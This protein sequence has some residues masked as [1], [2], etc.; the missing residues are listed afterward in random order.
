MGIKERINKLDKTLLLLG[1]IVLIAVVL[2][3][4]T[5]GWQQAF[6]GFKQAGQLI[7]TVWLRLLLGF[8]LG[9]LVQVLI[10]R[11][12]IAKWLG[13]ASGLKGILIGSYMSII[14]PGSPYVALPI[15]ASIYRAGAGVGPVIAL[16]T[17][18]GILEIQMLVVWEIPFLGVEIP[19]ARYVACLL[20]PPIV[21][22]MGATVFRMITK[23]SHTADIDNI[24]IGAIEQQN[25]SGKNYKTSEEEEKTE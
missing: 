1:A 6:K 25:K 12:L 23:L 20:I 3:L 19:L 15:I 11:V 7:N 21:G 24:G 22:L 17:G 16:L 10:P 5:G 13:H 8:T 18:R 9:G 14:I 2:A 4:S